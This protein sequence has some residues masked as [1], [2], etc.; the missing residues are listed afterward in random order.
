LTLLVGDVELLVGDQ[1]LGAGGLTRPDLGV[2][3]VT[4]AGELEPVLVGKIPDSFERRAAINRDVVFREERDDLLAV[5]QIAT[6]TLQGGLVVGDVDATGL[7]LLEHVDGSHDDLD[8]RVAHV[9]PEE[10]GVV[11]V[12]VVPDVHAFA[13]VGHA[14]VVDLDVG[15]D[16]VLSGK[17]FSSKYHRNGAVGV[18]QG[19]CGNAFGTL[20]T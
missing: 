6:K 15:V 2:G 20:R 4:L 12:E 7:D 11:D 1:E 14:I 19:G 18:R 3:I 13:P 9:L 10:H 8:A 17:P 16:V 5:V